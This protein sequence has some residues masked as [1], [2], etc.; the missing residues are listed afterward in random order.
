[1]YHFITEKFGSSSV[2]VQL[3]FGSSSIRETKSLV[4]VQFKIDEFGPTNQKVRGLV[5]H[6]KTSFQKTSCLSVKALLACSCMYLFLVRRKILA[7][8]QLLTHQG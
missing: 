5:V 8:Q 2:Q 1:M 7:H 3:E 4:R 6:K